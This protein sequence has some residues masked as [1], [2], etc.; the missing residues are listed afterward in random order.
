MENEG[1]SYNIN[2]LSNDVQITDFNK[3]YEGL[4]EDEDEKILFRYPK[5]DKENK[6]LSKLFKLTLKK[7][8]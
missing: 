1:K 5:K 6:G 8:N 2:F 7:N 4:K 3:K